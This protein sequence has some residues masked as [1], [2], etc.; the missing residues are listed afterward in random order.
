MHRSSTHKVLCA[1]HLFSSI[2]VS[3]ISFSRETPS[4]FKKEVIKAVVH[5][6]DNTGDGKVV[7]DCLNKI[8]AN[9][10]QATFSAEE[11]Q[12]LMQDQRVLAAA[13]VPTSKVLSELL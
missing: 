7:V 11:S 12:T 1:L 13:S 2:G 4:R 6:D 3:I 5:S 9:I 10:G 8:L